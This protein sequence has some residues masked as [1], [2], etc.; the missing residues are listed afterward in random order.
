[1]TM[2]AF[3]GIDW[4][5]TNCRAYRLDEAGF[6][7]ERRTDGAGILTVRNSDFS[8]ALTRIAGDWIEAAGDAAVLMCGMIGSA[9]GWVEAPYLP[10]P[11]TAKDIAAKLAAVADPRR[12]IFIV[13]G[14][15]GHGPAGPDVM[16]GEETQ[17][18]G[19]GI[20]DGIV[21]LPGT[22]SKWA[23]IEAGRIV[24]FATFM[25]GEV[26]GVMRRNSILGRLM[27]DAP[28]DA[29]AFARGLVRAQAP[30]GLLHQLF[31]V[32]TAGLLEGLD[33]DAGASFL[34]GVLVGQEIEAAKA[35]FAPANV[36]VIGSHPLA[37]HYTIGLNIAGVAAQA[38]SG[39]DAAARGLYAIA[40]EAGLVSCGS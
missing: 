16:R 26:F 36:T 37:Q 24:R 25:T 10:V 40:R 17:I 5:T 30:G 1:M 22:H 34:S 8:A 14:L 13:P 9:Q 20:T 3:V 28:H 27:N 29:A 4:G 15:H 31:T 38:V 6:V 11:A 19:S 32:R 23:V 2:A 12:R 39:E 18:I 21:C 7:L 35:Q 33:R